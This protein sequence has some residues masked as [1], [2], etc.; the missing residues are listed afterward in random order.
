MKKVPTPA[1]ST[2]ITDCLFLLLLSLFIHVKS[3]S[4]I[5]TPP[6]PQPPC[7]SVP[8]V[9]QRID[10]IWQL[11]EH[12]CTHYSHQDQD[13]LSID[14]HR[15]PQKNLVRQRMAG[16]ALKNARCMPSKHPLSSNP[17]HE[18]S[19]GQLISEANFKVFT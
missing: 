3:G 1:N 9:L 10:M 16:T 6:R 13:G 4:G 12:C 15:S 17:L 7:P 2:L 8:P 5:V 18:S 19:K 11:K 14:P